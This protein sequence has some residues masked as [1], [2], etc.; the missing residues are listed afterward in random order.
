M[1][2]KLFKILIY[3]SGILY[4]IVMMVHVIAIYVVAIV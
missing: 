3:N 4:K 1:F 2:I